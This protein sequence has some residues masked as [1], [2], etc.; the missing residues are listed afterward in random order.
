MESLFTIAIVIGIGYWF[1][2]KG[3]RV[4]SR[5]GFNAGRHHRRRRARRH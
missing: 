4:G 5:K 3:K 2:R 1:Y